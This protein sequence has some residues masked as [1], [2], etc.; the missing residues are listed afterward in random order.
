M[1]KTWLAGC[2]P[3]AG[4]VCSTRFRGLP[5]RADDIEMFY[6]GVALSELLSAFIMWRQYR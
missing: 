4:L 2:H 6:P 1:L 5:L 3:A